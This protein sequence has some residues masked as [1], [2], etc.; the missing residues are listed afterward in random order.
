VKLVLHTADS[1]SVDDRSK[2]YALG[3]GWTHTR[4]PTPPMALLAFI[5]LE[6]DEVPTDISIHIELMDSSDRL[7]HFQPHGGDEQG[8]PVMIDGRVE[9]STPDE[10]PYQGEPIRVPFV[11]QLGP[12]IVL[13]PVIH[14]FHAVMTRKD[15]GASVEVSQYFRVREPDENPPRRP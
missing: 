11:V 5:D 4:S 10:Y 9:A 2:A 15:N 7:V 8:P 13:A 14:R 1:A 12:G 3:L 6:P